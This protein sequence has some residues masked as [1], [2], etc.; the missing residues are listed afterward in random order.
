VHN[1][2]EPAGIE[3]SN[4][5]DAVLASDEILKVIGQLHAC[6]DYCAVWK[7]S[8]QKDERAE[9]A[10]SSDDTSAGSRSGIDE[11]IRPTSP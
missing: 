3:Q 7:D 4:T 9:T 11:H 10:G 2:N 5:T 8:T 1:P 6:Y